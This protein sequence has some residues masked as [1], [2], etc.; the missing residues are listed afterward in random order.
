MIDTIDNII[1]HLQEAD[2]IVI[3]AGAGMGV[4]AG[5]PDF[6]GKSGIWTAE[7]DNFI[8]FATAESF[9]TNPLDSW[10]FYINRFLMYKEI[11][12]HRGYHDLL[13]L[14]K[15]I[16]VVTSNVDGHFA[17]SGYNTNKLYEIHGN[18][19]YIQCSN[20]CCNDTQLMPSFTQSLTHIDEIPKCPKCFAVSRP[21]IM[22]FNDPWFVPHRA[23]KQS[24][25]FME[26]ESD[27]K[28]I[29]GIEIG[30]GLVVPSI[31]IMGEERTHKLIRINPNDHQISRPNDIA[32]PCGALEGIDIVMKLFRKEKV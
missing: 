18:L 13:T 28:T 12:P 8:K 15:D 31:R 11:Q 3:L 6:R 26:W 27:K 29:I 1:S 23:T 24:I 30:A 19:D 20:R 25:R 32:I 14:Q 9:H 16:F 2:G 10:N 7:K 17:K 21:Q 22:M 5:I 4:D